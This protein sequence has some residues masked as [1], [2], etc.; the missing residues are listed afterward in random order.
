[1]NQRICIAFTAAACL[2][3]LPW[4]TA[5]QG[6]EKAKADLFGL[7]R[8]H[9]FHLELS[10][11]EW[12]T[13]QP[14]GGMPFF[15]FGPGPK[16]PPVKAD[17]SADVHRGGSFGIEFPWAKAELSTEGVTYKNV[18]LRYKGGGSY[19]MSAT[20]LKRNFKVELDHYDADVRFHGHKKLLS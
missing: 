6:Q 2:A 15:P 10:A 12:K 18:G 5:T 7:T 4:Q 3:M 16:K 14:A 13:M 1:M 20:R 9:S 17:K 11:K 8:T 19:V